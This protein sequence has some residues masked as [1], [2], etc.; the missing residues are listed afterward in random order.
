MKLGKFRLVSESGND[1]GI[2][3]TVSQ[4]EKFA[5]NSLQVDFSDNV[6]LGSIHNRYEG[7]EALIDAL[8]P[9]MTGGH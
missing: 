8:L 7:G 9:H 5:P 3:V 6:V 4:N 1:T 2:I